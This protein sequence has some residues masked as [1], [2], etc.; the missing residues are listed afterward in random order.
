MAI[1][2]RDSS[3]ELLRIIIMFMILLLHANFLAFGIPQDHSF[4]SFS[5][6][7]AEAFTLSPVNIFVLITGFFGTRFSIRKSMSLIYQVFFCVVPISLMLVLCG[8]VD[9]DYRYFVFHKYWF[10]NAY[11]GL[12]AVTPVLNVAAERFSK[13]EIKSFLIIFYVIAFI[14]TLLGLVGIEIA[15]G[16]SLL[17]FIFLY[18]LGRYVKMYEPSLS[19]KQLILIILVSCLSNAIAIFVLHSFDY[20]GPF[21]V[22]QSVSTLLLFNKFKLNCKLI[23]KI[24][25]S[26]TM[27]YLVNLHPALWGMEQKILFLMNQRFCIPV[28]L[29]Y[30]VLTSMVVFVFAILY[31]NLRLFTWNK[32]NSIFKNKGDNIS[33]SQDNN[34]EMQ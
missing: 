2:S 15:G 23:N 6:C 13:K 27:V 11:I 18:L 4:L 7:L 25:I 3:I 10:I 17:W 29:L 19:K 30:I 22:V 1:Q 12:L 21:L 33:D 5:R 14:G 9:F 8:I 26:T 34:I 32:L 28:F 20:V 31:D 24:A 16:C